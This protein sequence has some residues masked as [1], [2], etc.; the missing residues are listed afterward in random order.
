MCMNMNL[1]IRDNDISI[2]LFE[3]DEKKKPYTN[4]K[5]TCLS[6]R[7]RPSWAGTGQGNHGI[8]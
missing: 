3:G 4:E 2:A 6:L 1:C 7:E 8:L 5:F